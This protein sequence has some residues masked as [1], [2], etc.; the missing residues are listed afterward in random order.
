MMNYKKK[1][2]GTSWTG[3]CVKYGSYVAAVIV[4]IT[5][6]MNPILLYTFCSLHSQ[7]VQNIAQKLSVLPTKCQKFF[8]E[9]FY[10]KY[11]VREQEHCKSCQEITI[12]V[13]TSY[14]G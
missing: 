3:K 8:I 4:F 2:T 6:I 14:D 7:E 11:R 5:I 12:T 1:Q 9:T 13:I 10:A